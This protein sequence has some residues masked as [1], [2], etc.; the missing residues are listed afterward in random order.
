MLEEL[1]ATEPGC[2][3]S[4]AFRT[5]AVVTGRPVQV[6]EPSAGA[7]TPE[8]VPTRRAA[9]KRVGGRGE[10]AAAVGTGLL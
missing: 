3:E 5:V 6:V 7:T 2:P 4:T 8:V 10:L 9:D 1:L